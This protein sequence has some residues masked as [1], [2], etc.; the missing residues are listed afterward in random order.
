MRSL[1]AL[2]RDARDLRRD[3]IC[4]VFR[5][6]LAQELEVST[7]FVE[8]E[9]IT[10]ELT[11]FAEALRTTS[12]DTKQEAALR[13]LV[14]YLVEQANRVSAVGGHILH[15]ID[16]LDEIKRSPANCEKVDLLCATAREQLMKAGNLVADYHQDIK[17]APILKEMLLH[18]LCREG[19]GG[20]GA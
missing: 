18:L 2:I 11:Q 8:I 6:S 1:L 15:T 17:L 5:K 13:D 3:D 9:L 10:A 4:D 20:E 19:P 16:V 7:F 12:P 14:A